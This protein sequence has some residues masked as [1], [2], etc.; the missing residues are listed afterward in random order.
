ML[1]LGPT[2][3]VALTVA[4]S[5]FMVLLDSTI[6]NTS[7]P[8]MAASLGVET[9]RLTLAVTVY[10]LASAAVMPSS[11]WVADRFG[12]RRSFIAG[13][14]LF[15]LASALCG[16]AQ[17]L[18]QLVVARALQ[19]IGGGLMMP[20]GRILTIRR[21]TK[22][23]LLQATALVTWPAL[24]A[25][26]I[27]PAIGGYIST[28]IDWRWNFW[29]NVPLGLVALFI[30]SR[31]L[32]AD[33][34]A[35]SAPFDVKGALLAALGSSA[36]LGG[37]EVAPH[38]AHLPHG[39]LL[40]VAL[41]AAAVVLIA[42]LRRHLQR[43]AQPLVRLEPFSVRTF[44]VATLTGGVPFA[45]C[46]QATPFLLPLMFQIGLGWTA[47]QAGT[48]VLYYF[49]GNLL[50]KPATTPLLRRF[51]FRPLMI[52]CS[53]VGGATIAACGLIDAQWPMVAMA[54]LLFL[55]G[56]ARSTQLTAQN[57]LMFADIGPAH[58]SSASTLSTVLQQLA[59]A[60]GIAVASTLLVVS[61][62]LSGHGGVQQEDF[63]R[64]FWLV[65]ALAASCAV[66]FSRL[67]RDAGAE[68]SGHV[69]SA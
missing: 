3:R 26:V 40:A 23:E 60:F 17:S 16:F 34:P 47:V 10:P 25:P 42:V 46:L 63:A 39:E 4:A 45:M 52:G 6:L 59:G 24:M 67:P 37:L 21:A 31:V 49:L 9:L 14:V 57:T 19:G 55:T 8:N 13:L 61:S 48:M 69:R 68:V 11:G 27:G 65:G 58:R 18:P 41:I 43:A 2:Q 12:P 30:C 20:I 62:T 44:S 5:F 56:A 64:V 51:G 28:Y 1:S 50:I 54:V 33:P 22:A 38:A 35:Q 15:T 66:L 53:V 32:P 36:L 29:L 7:L